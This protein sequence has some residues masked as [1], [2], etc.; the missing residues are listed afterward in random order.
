MIKH[1]L[2]VGT[3]VEASQK[4]CAC[5][6]GGKYRTVTGKI[7]KTIVNQS[8]TWYYLDSG[9]TVKSEMIRQVL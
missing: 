8:G 6:G 9:A 2:T 4:T 7:L 1:P 5:S 3:K